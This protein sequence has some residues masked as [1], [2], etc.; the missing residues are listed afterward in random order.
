[1]NCNITEKMLPMPDGV[2][3]YTRIIEPCDGKEK[4]PIVFVRTPYG[5]VLT[6]TEADSTQYKIDLFIENG[7]AV[8]SQHC[9]GKIKSEGECTP[10]EEREDGL[11]TL[12]YIRKLPCYNGEIYIY[13]LSYLT[14]VHM[15]YLDTNPEDIKGAALDIQTDRMY[16]RNYRNGC[17]Y[18]W[19]NVNWWFGML[20][21]V[22]PDAKREGIF[23]RPYKDIMKR[24]IGEDY[25]PYTDMLLNDKY[26]EF[27]KNDPRTYSIDNLKIPV[28]LSEGWYDFYTEG[29]FSMWERLP[30][31]TREKSAFVVGPWGHDT[32]V[33]KNAQYPIEN[34][35]LPADFVVEW[36]NS[37]RNGESFKYA[38]KGK[39]NYYSLGSGEWRVKDYPTTSE[40][41]KKLWFGAEN[42]LSEIPL[43]TTGKITYEY[44]PEE[45][46]ACFEYLNVYEAKP[47]YSIPG[48][49][50]FVS[51]A[52]T[53]ETAFYGKVRWRM[54]VSSDC[55]DTA[56]FMRV[57][58]VEDG[59]AYNITETITSLS[60]INPDYTP[61]E[62][63]TIDIETPPCAFTL[64]PG[65]AIRVDISSDGGKYVPHANVKG[66]WA[67]VEECRIANNTIYLDNAYIELEMEK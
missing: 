16:F 4:H 37:I 11:A 59:K 22:Y 19:C 30:Q 12:E 10:Y 3:L 36:F 24:A 18:N 62:R 1:M 52:F 45:P 29:M 42:K 51:D 43:S 15:T 54:D 41:I 35:E 5:N 66:H 49:I 60:N 26:N 64:K 34:G 21:R 46:V 57:Y 61:N 47:M 44:N 53:E 27:W 58:M 6:G 38:E 55:E 67:E 48:V 14:T 65:C 40:S 33:G 13:G 23:T 20:D 56:F 2:K 9:R 63:L 25:P 28:L 8:V 7:Y 32:K 50:S 39:V 31:A 17:C